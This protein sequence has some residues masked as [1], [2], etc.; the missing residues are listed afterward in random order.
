[1]P[2]VTIKYKNNIIAE[3][4][5]STTSKTLKTSGK[6]CDGDINV[7]Y[8]PAQTEINCKMYEITL[9]KGSEWIKLIDLDAEVLEHIND[10]NFTVLLANMSDYVYEFYSGA[11]YV[12]S[13]NPY[14]ME[15]GY[16]VYGYSNRQTSESRNI[17]VGMFYPANNTETSTNLGGYGA[18]RVDGNKYYLKPHDGFIR[19]GKYRLLFVW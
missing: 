12:A 6:Y 2:D 9:S 14:G 18:F 15:N 11:F 13:N 17:S 16:P 1:M 10:K 4:D 7:I 19:A 3:L 8:A 5:S